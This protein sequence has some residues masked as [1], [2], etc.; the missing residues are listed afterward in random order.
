[1]TYKRKTRDT[2]ELWINY[3]QGWEHELTEF[4]LQEIKERQT[5]YW[6]NY[7]EYPTKVKTR[8]E[9]IEQQS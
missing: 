1:M 2:W 7:P 4:T 8:R 3:G 6:D 5:E 9:S